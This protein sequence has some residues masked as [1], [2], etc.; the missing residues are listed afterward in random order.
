VLHALY[1]VGTDVT[2]TQPPAKGSGGGSTS[3]G[4]RQQIKSLRSGA[5]AAGTKININ[6]LVNS[7]Y[8]TL[9]S[10]SLVTIARQSGVT[11]VVGG[12]RSPTSRSPG[13]FP[14]SM[15]AAAS[16]RT[17]PPTRSP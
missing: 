5:T 11:A 12:S 1:G 14:R 9:S 15:A 17:S 2:V 8:G 3:F 16:A 10:G 4:F 7:Q 13:R 6:D